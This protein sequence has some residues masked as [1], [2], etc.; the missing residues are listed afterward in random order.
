MC[1]AAVWV[2]SGILAA[3]LAGCAAENEVSGPPE[4]QGWQGLSG[5]PPTRAEY[6]AMVAACQDGAVRRAAAK[7]LDACLADLGLRR[8]E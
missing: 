5:K 8:S 4:M 2:V 3:G 7:P 1:R 6:T